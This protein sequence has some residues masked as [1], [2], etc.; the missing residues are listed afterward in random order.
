MSIV[1]MPAI[2]MRP[3]T[4][5]PSSSSPRD[6][7][8]LTSGRHPPPDSNA[9]PRRP[10]HRVARSPQSHGRHVSPRQRGVAWTGCLRTPPPSPS[11]RRV[12]T[13]LLLATGRRDRR[14]AGQRA[15][16]T[17]L[18]RPGRRR[19]PRRP[20]R[21]ADAHLQRRARDRSGSDGAAGDG[22]RRHL[23]RGRRSAGR[24]HRGDAAAQRSGIRSRHRPVEGRL[25]RR[26]PDLGR[27]RVLGADGA[28]ADSDTDGDTDRQHASPSETPTT[29]PTATPTVD[30]VPADS[31][32]AALPVGDRRT[33]AARSGRR[34]G[35]LPARLAS[36]PDPRRGGPARQCCRGRCRR[37][38]PRSEP[39]AE[40]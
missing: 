36:A 12:A 19:H 11:P 38:A 33:A 4:S 13:L 32:N 37:P 26:A 6:A 31:G 5:C 1:L 7:P 10:R 18:D 34:R 21:S 3:W 15:R 23:S 2:D 28:D 9:T 20:P 16:R 27:V 35:G 24:G 17:G 40:R 29:E 30:P 14:L 25:Q 22:C 39:P 8:F